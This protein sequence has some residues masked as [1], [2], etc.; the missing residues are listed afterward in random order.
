MSLT[1]YSCSDPPNKLNKTLITLGS[2]NYFKPI[3]AN[4]ETTTQ[5]ILDSGMPAGTNYIYDSDLRRYFFVVE[6]VHDIAKTITVNCILDPL[7]T[8]RDK[9]GGTFYFVR[10]ADEVN[11]ME[12]NSYPLSDYIRTETYNIDGWDNNFFKNS[13]GG[14]RFI[15]KTAVGKASGT[16]HTT[17]ELTANMMVH[18]QDCEY[19]VIDAG[20]QDLKGFYLLFTG[21]ATSSAPQGPSLEVDD[22]CVWNGVEWLIADIGRIQASDPSQGYIYSFEWEKY[23]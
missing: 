20:S 7:Y 12:D 17:I 22:I 3:Y 1:F 11:E 6:V 18:H 2:T 21:R 9:L 15:L 16:V 13:D 19:R 8:F 5:Y 14:Y 23:E 10:G 4:G